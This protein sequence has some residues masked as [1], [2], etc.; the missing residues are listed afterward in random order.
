MGTST[1]IEGR[2]KIANLCGFVP[3][4][5][6]ENR[7]DWP[8]LLSHFLPIRWTSHWF[9]HSSRCDVIC[10]RS[11]SGTQRSQEVSGIRCLPEREEP[12]CRSQSI[13]AGQRSRPTTTKGSIEREADEAVG[14][15]TGSGFFFIAEG[16]KPFTR[17]SHHSIFA[18]GNRRCQPRCGESGTARQHREAR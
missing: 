2:L 4:A 9:P 5:H 12:R 17:R 10:E 1:T 3:T 18:M 14:H 7:G 8:Q 13:R 16:R 6:G 15:W 11:Q